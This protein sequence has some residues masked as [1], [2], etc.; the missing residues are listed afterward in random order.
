MSSITTGDVW[1]HSTH[2]ARKLLSGVSP[3][4]LI[5]SFAAFRLAVPTSS[6]STGSRTCSKPFPTY[7]LQM[8]TQQGKDSPQRLLS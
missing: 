4:T 1:S 2:L 7:V 5:R 3:N 6:A 8:A